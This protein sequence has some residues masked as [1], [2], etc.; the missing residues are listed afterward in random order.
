MSPSGCRRLPASGLYCHKSGCSPPFSNSCADFHNAEAR[1][2][3]LPHSLHQTCALTVKL[4]SNSA[5]R[6]PSR[7]FCFGS[8]RNRKTGWKLPSIRSDRS[9]LRQIVSE[10]E[11]NGEGNPNLSA[12][13]LGHE[14]LP[15]APGA[16]AGKHGQA[17]KGLPFSGGGGRSTPTGR[18]P[19]SPG[20]PAIHCFVFGTC[21]VRTPQR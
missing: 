6:T 14:A 10:L 3:L 19:C 17:G 11:R 5:E 21:P 12:P 15:M 20:Q 16:W 4:P 2:S 1:V 18:K 13:S 9:S 8:G 7:A